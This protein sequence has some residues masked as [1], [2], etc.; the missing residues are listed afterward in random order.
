VTAQLTDDLLDLT[1][2]AK[3]RGNAL[4]AVVIDLCCSLSC[5]S[6]SCE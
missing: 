2:E 5:T 4:Y 3:G 1:A 6:T